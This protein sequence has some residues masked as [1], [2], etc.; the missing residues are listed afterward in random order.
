[1]STA[2]DKQTLERFIAGLP[3]DEP[4]L[5]AAVS[6]QAVARAIVIDVLLDLLASSASATRLAAARRIVGMA[7]VAPNVAARLELIA[8][9]DDD[10]RVRAQCTDA[11]R[12]HRLPVRGD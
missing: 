4:A 12:A 9:E 10:P 5:A 7:S 8:I 11:L 2:V 6:A 3:T 1:M